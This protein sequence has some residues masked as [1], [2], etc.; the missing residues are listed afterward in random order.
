ML[1]PIIV[2]LDGSTCAAQALEYA[3]DLAKARGAKINICA[4]VDPIA[5]A[6]RNMFTPLK[7]KHMAD[8]KIEADRVVAEAL[9]KARTANVAADGQVRF[10][11]PWSEIIEQATSTAAATIVMGTHGRSGFRRFFMG[12]VAQE[13]LRSAPCPVLIVREKVCA[14]SSSGP[15]RKIDAK[16]PLFVLRLVE[17]APKDFERLY[18]E[19]ASFMDGPGA[20][21]SG[22]SEA[23]VLGSVDERRIVILAEFHSHSDW[24]HAQW[25]A[26]LGELLEEIAVN[27]QTLEFNL[28]R[29]DRFSARVTA[30][31]PVTSQSRA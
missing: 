29:G 3:V 27:S 7:E 4:V 25:D 12:S 2:P 10:G 28:Y 23:Q 8:A 18:G 24:V 20:Q 30:A 13:V 1:G 9:A 22:I 19:I 15:L 17:V 5:I 14:S 21:L 26:K 16:G 6:G 11:E 31:E